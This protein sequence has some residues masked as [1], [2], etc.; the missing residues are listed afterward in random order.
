[1][2]S[3]SLSPLYVRARE[4]LTPAERGRIGARRKWGRRRHVNL[5][6]LPE[7]VRRAVEALIEAEEAAQR[8][9]LASD[10]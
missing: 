1:M 10:G 8:R 5:T 2:A 4:P 9:E 7:P 3:E 6:E